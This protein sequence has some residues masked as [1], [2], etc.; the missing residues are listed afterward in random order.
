MEC[1]RYLPAVLSTARVVASLERQGGCSFAL[2]HATQ[3]RPLSH[4][5]VQVVVSLK[6]LEDD[7]LKETL[8]KVLPLNEVSWRLHWF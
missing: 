5:A 8:D 3:P 2:P 4:A 1:S 7:P 6:R